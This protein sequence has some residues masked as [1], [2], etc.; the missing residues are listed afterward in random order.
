M[1]DDP[2]SLRAFSTA[3]SPDAAMPA[4]FAVLT[5]TP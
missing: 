5:P 1:I 2:L 4:P 3:S